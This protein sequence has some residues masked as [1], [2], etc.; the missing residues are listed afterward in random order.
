MDV[1]TRQAGERAAGLDERKPYLHWLHQG[2]LWRR[3]RP[4]LQVPSWER[5]SS[6]DAGFSMWGLELLDEECLSV[7]V[8]QEKQGMLGFR[9]L[10]SIPVLY[11]WRSWG[12]DRG[13]GLSKVT[14]QGQ[15]PKLK[16]AF[17]FRLLPHQR[18][19]ERGKGREEAGMGGH[20]NMEQVLCF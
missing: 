3:E 6:V 4:C 14:R 8:P 2:H 11:I 16:P 9:V 10:G 5:R 17:L 18:N 13:S 12:W 19:K 20:E 1:G 15:E 7:E